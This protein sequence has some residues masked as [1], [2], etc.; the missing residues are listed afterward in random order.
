MEVKQNGY[1]FILKRQNLQYFDPNG[2]PVAKT[3][4]KYRHDSRSAFA[5]FAKTVNQQLG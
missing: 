2:Q 1:T 5:D 3:G 4:F